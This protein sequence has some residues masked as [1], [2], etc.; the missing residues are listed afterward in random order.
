MH[1]RYERNRT[2]R[3]TCATGWFPIYDTIEG[4][5]GELYVAIRVQ[6]Y[7]DENPFRDSSAGIRFFSAS[8]LD[9]GV[10]VVECVL[11]FVEELVVEKDP[12]YEWSDSFRSARNSN[13]SRQRL[14][15]RLSCTLTRLIGK[16]VLEL[17][18]DAV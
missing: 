13:E 14:L 1:D 3:R 5:R 2:A 10:F 8:A 18:G 12:E 16:K 17:G 9:P 4:V 11:G 15:Y 7:G 6:C